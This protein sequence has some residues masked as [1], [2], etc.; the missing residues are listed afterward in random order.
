MFNFKR[1]PPK[2]LRFTVPAD[3]DAP[4]QSEAAGE[5]APIRRGLLIVRPKQPYVN[6]VRQCSDKPDY[7]LAESRRSDTLA[8]L[9]PSNVWA[10][11]NGDWY[12]DPGARDFIAQYWPHFFAQA[13]EVWELAPA[14]WPPER[15][16]TMFRHWFDLEFFDTVL[17]LGNIEV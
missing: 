9:V 7:H 3:P 13:L 11:E 2:D 8:Y 4:W 12:E 15:N 1:R 14:V 17:D 6:W 5:L 10:D 16:L